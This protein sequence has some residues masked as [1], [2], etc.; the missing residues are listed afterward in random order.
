MYE[1]QLQSYNHVQFEQEL[2]RLFSNITFRDKSLGGGLGEIKFKSRE[3]IRD[4]TVRL[5]AKQ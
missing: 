4:E 1:P 2:R 3:T 5:L